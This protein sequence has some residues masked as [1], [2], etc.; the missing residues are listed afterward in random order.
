MK[1]IFLLAFILFSEV[2]YSQTVTLSRLF[3]LQNQ[4][5][6]KSN[7]FF[8]SNNW[9]VGKAKNVK[10]TKST[11]TVMWEKGTFPIVQGCRITYYDDIND[12]DDDKMSINELEYT[13]TNKDTYAR[14][15]N[16]VESGGYKHTNPIIENEVAFSTYINGNYI[17]AIGVLF[18]DSDATIYSVKVQNYASYYIRQKRR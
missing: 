14:I 15:K 3:T 12:D 18:K 6:N 10:N 17:I 1:S 2:A 7:S 16:E 4:D 8:I 5:F 13:F 9:K 11:Y